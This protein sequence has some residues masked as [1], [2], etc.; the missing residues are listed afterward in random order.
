MLVMMVCGDYRWSEDRL[1]RQGG[2]C[3]EEEWQNLHKCCCWSFESP[4]GVD[5]ASSFA[6]ACLD[7]D[8]PI[9]LHWEF[10]TVPD[11]N[12]ETNPLCL[13]NRAIHTP[14]FSRY[15]HGGSHTPMVMWVKKDTIGSPCIQS[16]VGWDS[17]DREHGHADDEVGN[18]EHGNRLIQ[19]RLSHHEPWEDKTSQSGQ[20][21]IPLQLSSGTDMRWKVLWKIPR[22]PQEDTSIYNYHSLNKQLTFAVCFKFTLS[23]VKF[24]CETFGRK[25]L[26]DHYN[27]EEL[28]LFL[29]TGTWFSSF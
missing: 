9:K 11:L 17:T 3:W 4:A 20:L 22:G 26:V 23:N 13:V 2:D 28:G 27:S 8:D 21:L 25:W 7:E 15:F 10:G 12:R 1:I 18:Q 16:P 6:E 19:S 24:H 14:V 29:L 5:K